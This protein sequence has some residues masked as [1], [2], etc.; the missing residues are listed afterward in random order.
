MPITGNKG[1]WSEIYAFF[2]ILSE[3]NLYPADNTATRIPNMHFPVI[4]VIREE[5]QGYTYEYMIGSNHIDDIEIKLNNDFQQSLP[6]S[7]FSSEANSLYDAINTARG[8]SFTVPSSECF[9][10]SIGC[11]ILKPTAADKRDITLQIHDIITGYD[12]TK[13]YSIKS[14]IGG[15]PTLLNASGNVTNFKYE[16][17]GLTDTEIN[18]INSINTSSKIL[19]RISTIYDRASSVRFIAPCNETFNEN[20]CLI[21]SRMPELVA[22]LLL[23]YYNTRRMS[24]CIDIINALLDNNRNP[25]NFP[26]RNFYIYKFKKL[27][28]A[29]ALGMKPGS[30]W[31]GID[32]ATGGCIIVKNT[33]ELVTYQIHNRN[34][35]EDYLFLTT[36]FETPSS[37]RHNFGTLYNEDGH[38]IFKLGLQIR[39]I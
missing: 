11:Y 20:L 27:L 21:D 35:F 36:K 19:D 6:P 23:C 14:H 34:V 12:S 39:F 5:T 37:T 22:H 33:G 8:S 3:G 18:V 15:S 38:T 10:N 25:M 13:G 7:K 9:M 2:K 26:K 29:A 4:K 16:V 24:S 17:A 1:E 28:S 31:D 32:D 30:E